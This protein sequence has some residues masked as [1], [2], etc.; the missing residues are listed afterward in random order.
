[1]ITYEKLSKQPR[2]FRIMTG[3]TLEEFTALLDKFQ[4][5]WQHFVYHRFLSKERKRAY[6]GGR[7]T[8]LH[9]LEDK[10]I[11]I[12]VYTRIYPLMV[13]QG[14]FFGFEDS[15]A[16]DWVHRLL[17]LLDET[18]GFAH[19]R[20][21]R[22]NGR[23]LEEILIEFPEIRELGIAID[24]VERAKRRPKN[25]DKQKS[26]YSGKKKRHT[27]KNVVIVA[28]K[29]RQ[30][31]FLSRTRDGTCHDKRIIDEESLTCHDPTIMAAADTGFIG[32]KIGSL[33]MVISKKNTKLHK[34]S[35][36]D[37]EQN[38]AISSCRV[39][40]EHAL[41]GA[42]INRSIQD[43]YRNMT[44]GMNDLLMSVACGLHN[45]RVV[46]RQGF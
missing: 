20:P 2:V 24:G 36:S 14:L 12:L 39:V 25:L 46:H 30:V 38:R 19:V 26:E 9:S 29:I 45:L 43:V 32:L 21:R 4:S 7:H 17:P 28:Q 23:S 15:R 31:L 35:D 22:S 3:L 42:K 8:Q 41:A 6:G 5:G 13:V 18:L 40:A 16:C 27:T 34:L 33:K 44:A 1:M 10:L 11:F 37:K